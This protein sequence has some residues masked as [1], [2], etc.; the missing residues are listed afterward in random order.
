[1]NVMDAMSVARAVHVTRVTH[2]TRVM[3]RPR[4]GLAATAPSL[5]TGGC[6]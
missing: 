5:A 6:R 3:P 4:P 2:V 1:M